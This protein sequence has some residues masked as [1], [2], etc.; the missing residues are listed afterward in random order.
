MSLEGR[1]ALVTGA[2][3]GIGRGLAIGLAEAGADVILASRRRTLLEQV[4]AEVTSRGCR[5]HVQELDVTSAESIRAARDATARRFGR[6]DVLV[7]NAAASVNAPAWELNE[8]DWD[9]VM[10]AGPRAT[11]FCCQIL[12]SLM[13]EAGYGKIINLSST[14]AL[15]VVPGASVYGASKA[16]IGYLTRALAAEWA[17]DGVRVN[18]L[19]PASTPT[20]SRIGKLTPERREALV[21]RIPLGR[22]GS[23]E[24]LVPAAVFLA[25]PESDFVTGHTLFV[26]GGWTAR[27]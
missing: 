8:S 20:P 2:S 23:V 4:A 24:D 13:R 12:G 5:A 19:A 16:A 27:S 15:G 25:G 9:A 1:V 22:L 3:E 14:L 18:A 6:L 26:D 17:S 10:G 7:N 21:A 11:F